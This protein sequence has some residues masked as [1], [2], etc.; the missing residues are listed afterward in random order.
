M[1][2]C[3]L[4]TKGTGMAEPPSLGTRCP[5]GTVHCRSTERRHAQSDLLCNIQNTAEKGGEE[6]VSLRDSGSETDHEL[7]TRFF[8]TACALKAPFWHRVP[9]NILNTSLSSFGPCDGLNHI[10]PNSRTK[11]LT[12][13]TSERDCVQR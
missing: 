4:Q 2:S 8:Q 6:R 10:P 13:R 3:V 5:E 12:L 7:S 11:I 9:G 1:M